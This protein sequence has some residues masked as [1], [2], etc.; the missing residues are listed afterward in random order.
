MK[1]NVKILLK[2]TA[3]LVMALEVFWVLTGHEPH[4]LG[5]CSGVASLFGINSAHC[6]LLLGQAN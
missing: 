6:S 3:L 5:V 1:L 4:A 2:T